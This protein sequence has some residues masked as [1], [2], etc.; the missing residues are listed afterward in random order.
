MAAVLIDVLGLSGASHYRK[1]VSTDV[2]LE[3]IMAEL[4]GLTGVPRKYQST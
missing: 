2:A 4:E 3:N 1:A